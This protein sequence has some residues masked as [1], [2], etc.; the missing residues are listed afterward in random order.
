[1]PKK[2]VTIAGVKYFEP[3]QRKINENRPYNLTYARRLKDGRLID[4]RYV[5]RIEYKGEIYEHQ[6]YKTTSTSAFA[7]MQEWG[8]A[9]KC[10]I[11]DVANPKRTLAEDF[12]SF[13]EYKKS[14][15]KRTAT[16]DNYDRV[17]RN[18]LFTLHDKR[19]ADITRRDI[20]HLMDT[21]VQIEK[22]VDGQQPIARK[23]KDGNNVPYEPRTKAM[24]LTA[25]GTFFRWC[26]VQEIIDKNPAFGID[27][28]GKDKKSDEK[29]ALTPKMAILLL[30]KCEEPISK[31]F[32]W[33]D[34]KPYWHGGRR[35][36]PYPS[37]YPVDSRLKLI[38]AIA[39][40]QG[41]RR[42]NILKMQIKE[43]DFR[44]K[45]IKIDGSKMKGKRPFKMPISEQLL[46]LL[47]EH[48]Y[49][50]PNKNDESY[51][52]TKKN[53]K[54]F[55]NIRH[56]LERVVQLAR[57]EWNANLVDGDEKFPEN[58]SMH[59][60]RHSFA[61][62]LAS[63]SIP[64]AI[65]TMLLDHSLKSQLGITGLYIHK[66]EAKMKEAMAKLPNIIADSPLANTA[67]KQA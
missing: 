58:V 16:I 36:T 47:K 13:I 54:P 60:L 19:T 62:W 38:I 21:I 14:K 65:L 31:V 6:T 46:P 5:G 34:N 10:E 28:D 37:N 22:K 9:K 23:D 43:I 66:I 11:D 41:L 40:C 50:L 53:G 26:I 56:S 24:I 32:H 51:L 55:N 44:N 48:F 57:K 27:F 67:S 63:E 52:F 49:N 2:V 45:W 39:L 25:L 7:E 42:S 17:F 3:F 35:V 8:A 30:Q 15:G 20:E 33:Q 1:M 59:S 4:I 12:K 61:S 64:I 29:N 18:N